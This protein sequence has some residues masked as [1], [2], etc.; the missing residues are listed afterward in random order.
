RLP[1]IVNLDGFYLSFTREPVEIPEPGAAENFVGGFDP[2]RIAFRA[3]LP[4]SQAVAVLG[5][6]PY[7]YFRY[8][9]HLAML[10]ALNVYP[11]VAAEFNEC[12]SR[13]HGLVECY[14][15][16]DADYLFVMIG[17][18][19]TKAKDAVIRLREAGIKFGLLRLRMIRPFPAA[20]V[21]ETAHGKRG[22]AVIDQ[23]LSTGKGG[24]LHAE[25]AS[26]LYGQSGAPAMLTSF[27]GGLGGRDIAQEEFFLIAETLMQAAA[28]GRT[29]PPKLLYTAGEF[30]E[31]QKLRAIAQAEREPIQEQEPRS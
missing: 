22:L 1:V 24:I 31:L 26:A 5:G 20:A 12:F 6:S 18:F 13:L 16:D 29:P 21:A 23:N 2:G 15:C 10:E 3:G 11:K 4:E 14:R 17:C 19:A 25:I 8:E 7:S 30:K 28:S 27:I 9:S